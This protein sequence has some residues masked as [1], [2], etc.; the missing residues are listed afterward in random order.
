MARRR[1]WTSQDIATLR[2]LYAETPTVEIGERLGRH[3]ESIY[4]KANRLGLKKSPHYMRARHGE[5]VKRIGA[6]TRFLPGQPAW[7]KGMHYVPGGACADTQFRPGNTPHN[8]APVGTYR[9]NRDGYLDR[10]VSDLRRGAR[11]WEAVHRLV[12][13]EAHGEIP[14]GHIVVFQPGRHSTVL[15]DI[16]PDA[17][18]LITRRE[19]MARNSV[20]R[21]PEEIK[22][23]IR[24]LGVLHRRINERTTNEKPDGRSEKPPVRD[25]RTAAGQ[26]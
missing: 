12:W 9:I 15:E 13:K 21:Y 17:L 22:Q 16:T 10:K 1:P 8:W 25:A 18:E 3:I 26:G 4:E 2:R 24:Q 19:L 23:A 11:D 20:H 5:Q 6:G 14:A 7:N